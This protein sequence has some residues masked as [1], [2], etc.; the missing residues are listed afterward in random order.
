MLKQ[1]E[2]S[3][4]IPVY[5]CDKYIGQAIESVLSQTFKDLELIIVNNHSSDKT[6]EIINR[7]KDPRIRL[8]NNPKT[9]SA[10][11][12]WNK[13]LFEAKG[14]YIKLLCADDI[15]YSSCLERQYSIIN[16]PSNEGIVLVCC[17][18]DI[19]NMRKDN[20]YKRSFKG[21]SG[22]L[23]GKEAIKKLVRAG[24][25]LIGEPAAV[26]FK[27]SILD[28]T[29]GFNGSIPYVIDLDLWC[30]ILNYGSIYIISESLCAFRVSPSSWSISLASSQYNNFK[31][32]LMKLCGDKEYELTFFDCL[33]GKIMAYINAL[34]RSMFYRLFVK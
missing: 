2:I 12:N 33:Q 26:L 10:E 18:R 34:L 23:S 6:L 5:N 25:N 14:K 8:I 32:F 3:V 30:R 31:A 28:R 11:E 21:S 9:L 29:G 24:T 15:L 22:K 19:I 17:G 16:E 7:Y 1:P 20:I 13:A 27:A 4:C